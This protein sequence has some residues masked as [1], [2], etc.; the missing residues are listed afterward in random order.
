MRWNE[1]G[2]LGFAATEVSRAAHR[3]RR[4]VAVGIII[5]AMLIGALVGGLVSVA[6]ASC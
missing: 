5:L 1:E 6:A 2:T 4:S 3:G